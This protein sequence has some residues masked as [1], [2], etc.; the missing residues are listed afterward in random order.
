MLAK[1][2]FAQFTSIRV[3]DMNSC[4]ARFDCDCR[5][6]ERSSWRQES[7]LVL[8]LLKFSSSI[9]PLSADKE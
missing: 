6:L 7:L 5:D 3:M 1:S 9:C 2:K 4:F 8:V